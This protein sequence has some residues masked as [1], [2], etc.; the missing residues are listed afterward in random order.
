MKKLIFYFYIGENWET[1]KANLA[2]FVC[3]KHYNKIFDEVEIYLSVDNRNDE[4]NLKKAREIFLSIF[5]NPQSISFHVMDNTQYRESLM[6]KEQIIDRLGDDDLV[7]TGHN[8]GFTD[9]TNPNY[10]EEFVITWIVGCY[11]YSLEDMK[12]VENT[13]YYD[14]CILSYGSFLAQLKSPEGQEIKQLGKYKWYYVGNFF[15]INSKKLKN[16]LDRNNIT[17]PLLGDRYYAENILANL[18]PINIPN[19]VIFA[20]SKDLCFYI[21]YDDSFLSIYDIINVVYGN[22]SNNL[23][24]MVD[25]VIKKVNEQVL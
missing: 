19:A 13:L 10:S 18:F 7:F 20:G 21:K 9:I 15:W 3:L 17:P 5:E 24:A 12:A 22:D 25:D 11:Y 6:V 16:Y 14:Q 8:K 4:V 23:Y 1:N 2:H